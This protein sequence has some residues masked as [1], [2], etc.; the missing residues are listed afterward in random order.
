M[1]T[2]IIG[3]GIIGLSTGWQLAKKGIEVEILE[4]ASAG[5]SASW[6][7]AGMLAPQAEMGFEDIDLFYLC[8]K[9]LD[10][11]PQFLEELFN[12]S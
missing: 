6:A 8:R 10:M 12:D 9:S 1:K 5:R 2:I 3:G 11:Y 4:K 7:A